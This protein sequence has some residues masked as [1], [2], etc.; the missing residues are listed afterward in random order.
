[1]ENPTQ[2]NHNLHVLC[3]DDD[4]D[5]LSSIESKLTPFCR[6]S[7]AQN[8]SEGMRLIQK[9]TVDVVLLDI[10]LGVEN[11]IDGLKAIKNEDPSIDVVMVTGLKDPKLVIESV[12]AGAFDYLCKPPD[13]EEIVIIL[14]KLNHT[15]KIQSRHDALIADLNS[16]DFSHG[17]VG[18]SASFRDVISTAERIRGHQAN[19]LILGENGTGKELMARYIHGLEENPR[20][21]FVAVNC[22]AIPEEL[23]E[24]EL[25]GHEKGSFTGAIARKIGKFELAAGGDIFLDEISALKTEL[26]AK[27]LRVLQEKEVM[28][29]GGMHP[30]KVDFRVISATNEDMEILIA[31]GRFRLDLYHRLCVVMLKIPPLRQR[32]EDIGFLVVYFIN[33]YSRPGNR[34]ELTPNAVKMLQQYGWPGNIRELENLIHNLVI[35]S[36]A[37]VIDCKDLPEWVKPGPRPPAGSPIEWIENCHEIPFRQCL[38]RVEKFYIERL[39]DRMGGNKTKVADMVGMSRSTLHARIKELGVVV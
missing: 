23:I 29:I 12:R 16:Q 4:P 38:Q 8:I 22:A 3:I 19:T 34:K 21:P 26:Q 25:F 37:K 39:L 27:L 9:E 18:L 10:G 20:R 33:K 6:C 13:I 14:E 17:M 35:M 32:I 2:P 24:S 1:M 30:I 7:T 36:P 11:G 31:D 15:R 5:F 28:R